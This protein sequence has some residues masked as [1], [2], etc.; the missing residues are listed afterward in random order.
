VGLEHVAMRGKHP[1]CRSEDH[2]PGDEFRIEFVAEHV[3]VER[4]EASGQGEGDRRPGRRIALRI[5]QVIGFGLAG[6]DRGC[7]EIGRQAG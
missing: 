1:L 2:A 4:R 5:S 6:G 3:A 7:K